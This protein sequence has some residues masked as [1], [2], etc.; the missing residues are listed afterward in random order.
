ML[1]SKYKKRKGQVSMEIGIFIALA[2]VVAAIVGIS[3][4]GGVKDTGNSYVKPLDDLNFDPASYI[5]NNSVN[6]TNLTEIQ[7][8]LENN[9]NAL[10]DEINSSNILN[11]SELTYSRNKA[12]SNESW[13]R[14]LENYFENSSVPP[15]DNMLGISNPAYP[16]NKGVL[17]WNS[18][19]NLPKIYQNPAVFI[20]NNEKY[21]YDNVELADDLEKLRGTVVFYKPDNSNI[22]EY[23]YIDEN[24]QKSDKETYKIN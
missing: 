14:I 17:N 23:Y 22:V 16:D 18:V 8:I 11:G 9:K 10:I 5:P 15:Y 7:Q 21:S 4:I 2:V 20:T 24:L 13:S 6:D 3:Y 1:K 19:G 12:G